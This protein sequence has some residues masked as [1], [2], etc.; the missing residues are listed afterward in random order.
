MCVVQQQAKVFFKVVACLLLPVLS[1]TCFSQLSYIR[2][3]SVDEG[4]PQGQVRG[5][6]QDEQ[7]FTWICSDGLSRYDGRN[8]INYRHVVND[9]ATVAD[10]DMRDLQIDKHNNLWIV[11]ATNEVDVVNAATGKLRHLSDEPAFR[12]MKFWTPRGIH[13]TVRQAGSQY[14]AAICDSIIAFDL[15]TGQQWPVTLPAG[16]KLMALG[17]VIAGKTLLATTR[18]IYQ[19]QN[20]VLQLLYRFPI[21]PDSIYRSWNEALHYRKFI[22]RVTED[23]N[24]DWIMP[25]VGGIYTYD[26]RQQIATYIGDPAEKRIPY[27]L[28][29][30]ADGAIYYSLP[31]GIYK[32]S[33]DR[34]PA[35]AY[36]NA[37]RDV[38]YEILLADRSGMLW[39]NTDVNG[40]SFF[41]VRPNNFH[42]SPYNINFAED[43]LQSWLPAKRGTIIY[44]SYYMRVSKDTG[45]HVWLLNHTDILQ[46]KKLKQT[47]TQLY[48]LGPSGA[49]T[50][51]LGFGGRTPMLFTF[52]ALNR[53]WIVFEDA[54]RNRL[55]A[56]VDMQ[57]GAAIPFVSLPGGW[58]E[59]G[60]LTSIDKYIGYLEED[61]LRLYD[62][63]TAACKVFSKKQLGVSGLLLMAFPDRQQKNILWIAT[64]GTGIVKL[65]IASGKTF[66]FEEKDGLP[67][68]SVYYIVQDKNGWFWCS[69]N[70]GL[71]RLNPADGSV[72]SFT[73]K[74][75]VQGNEFNRYH[76][77][78]TPDGQFYF[79]G[80]QGY[81]W[82]HPDSIYIDH[83]QTPVA[84]TGLRV[85][86]VPIQ[87]LGPIWKDSLPSYLQNIRLPYNQNQLTFSFAGLQYDAPE[88]LRY[89]Y[90]LQGIDKDWVNAGYAADA[91]YASIP[92]GHYTMLVNVA[93]TSGF[94]SR[95]IAR[96]NITITPPWWRTWWMYCFYAVFIIAAAWSFFRIR[97]RRLEMA[98][99]V[100]LKQ[101]EAEQ[102]H[103]MEEIKSRFFDNITHELRTPLT[104][105]LSPVQRQLQEGADTYSPQLLEDIYRNSQNLLRLT[106][107]LLD[108]SKLEGGRM[109]L[110]LHRGRLALFIESL[111][112]PFRQ[113]AATHGIDFLFLVNEEKKREHLFDSDKLEKVLYNLLSNAFKFTPDGGQI[114]LTVKQQEPQDSSRQ[115]ECAKDNFQIQVSD[116]GI[117]VAPGHLP[118]IFDRFY[119][120]NAS[121][122]RRH[123]GTGIG[124]SLVKELVD[125]MGG[126]IQV[127]SKVGSG[128]IF[129][130]HFS[131]ALANDQG[132]ALP[133]AQLK[134][135]ES[136]ITITETATQCNDD[137][138]LILVVED[139][140]QLRNFIRN[141][142]SP[143]YRIL[144]AVNGEDGLQAAISELPELIISDVMMPAMD[145]YMFC[146]KIKEAPL[147]A[148]IGFIMLTAKT[149]DESRMS[150]LR[151]GAD[152]Y[153]GK[154]FM[155]EELLLTATN[156]LNRQQQV[157]AFYNRQLQ[158]PTEKLQKPNEV[159][160]GFLKSAYAV[161][162]TNLDSERLDVEY[163]ATKLS[164]SRRT[165]NRK[166]AVIADTSANELI[167]HYRLKKAAELLI[168]GEPVSSTA[169]ATGF[170]TPSYFT[171][172]FKEMYGV[173]PAQFAEKGGIS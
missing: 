69:S 139:N 149:A 12:W 42:S 156:L 136:T 77:L 19:L 170:S 84:I 122:T 22:G 56:K 145:G 126:M 137:K 15:V 72:I 99:Q 10:N 131:L 154:P 9:T 74:D 96:L 155:V 107:Q 83:Y 102:A 62:T 71:F 91:N 134:P 127:E 52:D 75:G 11:Y 17:N 144:T 108:I 8:F 125:L 73:V 105:I 64:K 168:K 147:T 117:G 115:P 101:K 45:G 37:G 142:L 172:C 148:H 162:E 26:P 111:L 39:A 100:I 165:L 6:V 109:S 24:G 121:N 106:N 80:T 46:N 116:T 3:L 86:N 152:H 161:I 132:P 135:E 55:L 160:D 119:Q 85:N 158:Q 163:L 1:H 28:V 50:G 153:I 14:F 157:R 95:H 5:M 78:E 128:S 67:N 47:Y 49:I 118:Y 129:T 130:L 35:L 112:P 146:Q 31:A 173:S 54:E 33:D 20:R 124:L 66:H 70:S 2:Q 16:E 138:P 21:L 110:S 120:V 169:Y 90:Q 114:S 141:S 87:Q 23:K 29:K 57:P 30:A 133:P 61:E 60:Y 93:N 140:E 89:R 25:A 167:R 41:N 43:V 38:M 113:Q 32:I 4:L 34:P 159:E 97:L 171:Q 88:K 76:F 51:K 18:G 44:H 68:N 36:R 94:W 59:N 151:L 63:A 150:G 27:S 81:T 164:V 79:G 166:L 53:C 103:A 58:K 123:E 40:I 65:D 48:Q 7:G 104:L 13:F 82:F 92:P 98:Q 143:R